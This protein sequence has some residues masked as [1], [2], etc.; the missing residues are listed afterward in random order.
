[1]SKLTKQDKESI[2]KELNSCF[3]GLVSLDCDGYIVQA[4]TQK[5]AEMKLGIHVYVNGYFKGKWLDVEKGYDEGKRF[6]P[7][8]KKR[9]ISKKDAKILKWKE[10]DCVREFRR[11]WFSTPNAFINHIC[12]HNENVRVISSQEAKRLIEEKHGNDDEN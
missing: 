1:M 12:K 9:L 5:I 2:K 10:S 8:H 7:A 11:P 6:Y 4:S 3:G